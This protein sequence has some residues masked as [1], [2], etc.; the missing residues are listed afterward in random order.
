MSQSVNKQ[1]GDDIFEFGPGGDR[2]RLSE[3][4]RAKSRGLRRSSLTNNL[5]VPPARPTF[6]ALTS[7]GTRPSLPP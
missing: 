5:K 6:G 2:R 4:A 7:I 3:L 1:K